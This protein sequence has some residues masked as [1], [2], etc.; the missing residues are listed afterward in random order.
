MRGHGSLSGRQHRI[1][2]MLE[3]AGEVFVARLAAQL[4]VSEM[5]VRRDLHFLEQLGHVART[6]GG[7]LPRELEPSLGARRLDRAAEK[8]AIAELTLPFLS[9]GRHVFIGGSSTTAFLAERLAPLGSLSVTTTSLDIAERLG[10]TGR[11]DVYLIGGSYRHSS[12][13]LIGPEVLDALDRRLFDLCV[14]G[15]KGIDAEQGLLD[16]TEWHVSIQ[17]RLRARSKTLVVTADHSKFGVRSHFV[18]AR[19]D[20][21]DVLVTDRAPPPREAEALARAGVDVRF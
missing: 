3:D 17:R 8:A 7:A 16:A 2:E 20:E 12:R 10:R 21:L 13:T 11:H 18:T 6:H 4:G 14:I 5:T 19:L 15:I 1:L 9:A